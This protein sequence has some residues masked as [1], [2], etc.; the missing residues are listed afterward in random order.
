M[1]FCKVHTTLKNSFFRA[2]GGMSSSGIS[3]SISTTQALPPSLPSTSPPPTPICL[4]SNTAG[5]PVARVNPGNSLRIVQNFLEILRTFLPL[6]F[7][8]PFSFQLP[9]HFP[10]PFP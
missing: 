5:K 8:Y 10:S 6:P 2:S 3:T 7:Y 1:M 9:L 4:I